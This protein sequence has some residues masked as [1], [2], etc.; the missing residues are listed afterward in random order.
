MSRPLTQMSFDGF[1]SLPEVGQFLM[2]VLYGRCVN[3]RVLNLA[4][5]HGDT[6]KVLLWK[7][8][9]TGDSCERG[10]RALPVVSLLDLSKRC[11]GDSRSLRQLPLSDPSLSHALVDHLRDGSPVAHITLPTSS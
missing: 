6:P 10:T 2:Q 4:V 1:D 5:A 8:E 9:G 3:G 11:G 7:A